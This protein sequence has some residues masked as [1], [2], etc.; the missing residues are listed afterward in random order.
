MDVIQTLSLSLGSAWASGINLYATIFVLGMMNAH[1]GIDL[2]PSLDILSNPLILTVAG[3]M[4][5]VEFFADKIPGLDTAWD[6]IHTF[7]RIPAGIILAS[8]AL[9]PVHPAFHLAAALVGGALVTS[10]HATK[11]GTRILINTSPE[12]VSNWIASMTEDVLAVFGVWAALRHPYLF[13][14]LLFLFV[15]SLIWLLPIIYGGIRRIFTWL[16]SKFGGG[17]ARPNAPLPAS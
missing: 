4:F 14:F 12:P 16:A 3:V 2:P 7:I 10:T 8:A 11:A 1:G 17:K 15:L 5:L 6:A 9:G 13:L